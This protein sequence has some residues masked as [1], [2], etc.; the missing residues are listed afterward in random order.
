MPEAGARGS[1]WVQDNFPKRGEIR[2]GD[3][4]I[5]ERKTPLLANEERQ[6]QVSNSQIELKREND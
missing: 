3:R 5:K 4:V 1:L 2:T 6:G